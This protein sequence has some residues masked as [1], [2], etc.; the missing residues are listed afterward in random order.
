MGKVPPTSPIRREAVSQMARQQREDAKYFSLRY[1][2]HWHCMRCGRQWTTTKLRTTESRL[3]T[4]IEAITLHYCDQCPASFK[5]QTGTV[6][7]RT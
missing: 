6:E 1:E 7:P 5:L 4:L 3:P 2:C